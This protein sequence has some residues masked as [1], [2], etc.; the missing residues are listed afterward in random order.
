MSRRVIILGTGILGSCLNNIFYEIADTISLS[1]GD[2]NLEWGIQRIQNKFESIHK[3]FGSTVTVINAAAYTNVDGAESNQDIAMIINAGG[4]YKLAHLCKEF[5][6]KFIHIS[7]DFV[8]DGN[9]RDGAYTEYDTPNPINWYGYTKLMGEETVKNSGCKYVI[10]R[11]GWVYNKSN[12]VVPLLIKAIKEFS[13]PVGATDQ[14][15]TPTDAYSLSKQI[16]I[17]DRNNVT[18]IFHATCQG[19]ARPVEVLKYL[20]GI[21]GSNKPIRGIGLYRLNRKARRPGRCVLDNLNL[22]LLGIDV[23]PDWKESAYAC[24]L[25]KM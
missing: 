19:Y 23:M 9:I 21:C 16:D 7:S 10:V 8:F 5:G 13:E 3:E 18:G 17:I 2:I 20:S 24:S 25:D 6:W 4:P 22:R 1:R 11:T 15:I 12:G 14:V